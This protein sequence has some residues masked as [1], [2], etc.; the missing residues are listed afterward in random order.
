MFMR[1]V[2]LCILMVMAPFASAIS[3]PPEIVEKHDEAKWSEVVIISH[4][5]VWD[6]AMWDDVKNAG[7][8]PLRALNGHE[9][10]VWQKSDLNL[11]SLFS[12]VQSKD[13]EW[14]SELQFGHGD[15]E[16]IKILFEPRLPQ[17]A[18]SQIQNDLILIGVDVSGL[19]S[20]PY[21]VMPQKITVNMPDLIN[22]DTIS[23][24]PGILWVEPVLSTEGRNLVASAYPVSYTH[25]RAHETV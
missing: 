5:K 11:N 15:Y 24:I 13:A 19:S 8:H 10:L 1:G 6:L 25:L 18:Y 16:E 20:L 7:A 12:V 14:N 17:K 23:K 21:S 9:L 2:I 22:F 3:L 4:S